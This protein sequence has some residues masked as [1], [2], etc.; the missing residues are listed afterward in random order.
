[1]PTTKT[2]AIKR[3]IGDAIICG[4]KCSTK[5]YEELFYNFESCYCNSCEIAFIPDVF[6]VAELPSYGVRHA[7][8]DG[9]FALQF[10]VVGTGEKATC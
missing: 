9:D 2:C 4:E 10:D 3:P 1:M 8:V 5:K 6:S 7:H